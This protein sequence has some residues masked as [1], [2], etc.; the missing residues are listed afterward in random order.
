MN[1]P[2]GERL[3]VENP[4]DFYKKIGDKL[5]FDYPDFNAWILLPGNDASK[6]IGLRP[7]KK[8]NVMNGAFYCKFNKYELYSGSKKSQYSE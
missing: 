4:K 2:Y 5:K 8:A 1:P 3:D 7:A 6:M